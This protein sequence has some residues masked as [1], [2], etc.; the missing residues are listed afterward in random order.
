MKLPKLKKWQRV[1]VYWEDI[2]GEGPNWGEDKDD[3][4]PARCDTTGRVL[5]KNKKYLTLCGS[6]AQGNDVVSDKTVIPTG[7]IHRIEVLVP[8]SPGGQ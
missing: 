7:T 3:L 1:T 2:V 8:R 5:Y 6:R 4:F